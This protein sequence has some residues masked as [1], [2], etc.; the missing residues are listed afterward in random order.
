MNGDLVDDGASPTDYGETVEHDPL[1]FVS[2]CGHR[3]DRYN[4]T[5]EFQIGVQR[6][7][8]LLI[9]GRVAS[10]VLVS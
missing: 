1:T 5:R 2:K 9:L 3:H 6:I 8:D 10:C 4:R 7:L